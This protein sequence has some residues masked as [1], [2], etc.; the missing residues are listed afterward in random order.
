M[1]ATYFSAITRG[2]LSVNPASIADQNRGSIA[3]TLPGLAVGDLLQLEPPAALEG[4]LGYAGF[5]ISADTVT[6]YLYNS[7]GGAINGAALN[8]TYTWFDTTP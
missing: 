7:S 8:W 1:G 4:G 2:T 6:I 3:V 5:L